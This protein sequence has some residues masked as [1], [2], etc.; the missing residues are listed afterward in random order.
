[1]V[2]YI[3]EKQIR[4]EGDLSAR[5]LEEIKE[6]L[7]AE[8][9]DL[10]LLHVT[11]ARVTVLDLSTLQWIYAFGCAANSEGK[12]VVVTLNLSNE[13]EELVRISGVRKMFNRFKERR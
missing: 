7:T 5:R 6:Q 4:L 9:L 8:L 1:M 13:L 10:H 2:E 3:K 12:E 11:I